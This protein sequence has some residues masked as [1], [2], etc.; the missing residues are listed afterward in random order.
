MGSYGVTTEKDKYRSTSE[1]STP[2]S[3]L[4]VESIKDRFGDIDT[5]I[6]YSC[7]ASFN[8]VAIFSRLYINTGLVT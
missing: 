3:R 8:K 7:R 2:I 1:F 6:Y 4:S 5:R